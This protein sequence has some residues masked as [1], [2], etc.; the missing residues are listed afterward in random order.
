MAQG[1]GAVNAPPQQ[2]AISLALAVFARRFVPE[3]LAR[4][5]RRSQSGI[6]DVTWLAGFQRQ[7][8]PQQE[9]SSGPDA[10]LVC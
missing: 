1:P 8:W 3:A 7:E 9:H 2:E 4:A 5:R 10:R 6:A